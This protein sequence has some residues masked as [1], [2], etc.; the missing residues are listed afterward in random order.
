[1]LRTLLLS[2][3]AL[4]LFNCGGSDSA[5]SWDEP[6]TGVITTVREVNA[7]DFKIVSEDP[8]PRVSD[9]RIIVQPLDGKIDTFTLQEAKVIAAQSDTTSTRNRAVRRSRLG[10][11]GYMMLGRMTSGSSV[12]RGAY[13]SDNAYNRTN[14]TT[15][16]QVR[17]SARRVGGASRNSGFGSGR[18]SRSFGG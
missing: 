3:L 16:N 15:G 9:S 17:S 11:F 18:S 1:M 5:D 13:I 12:S 7:G 2:T 6:T 14:S 8:V 4:A 10:F